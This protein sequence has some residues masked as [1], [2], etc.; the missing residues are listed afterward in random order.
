MLNLSIWEIEVA[1]CIWHD[2]KQKTKA[3]IQHFPLQLWVTWKVESS[4]ESTREVRIHF[5]WLRITQLGFAAHSP[6][7]QQI[8]FAATRIG[9]VSV[10]SGVMCR[11]VRPLGPSSESILAWLGFSNLSFCSIQERNILPKDISSPEDFH[12]RICL[13]QKKAPAPHYWNAIMTQKFFKWLCD[14]L[15]LSQTN[16]S[17]WGGELN[18]SGQ[19]VVLDFVPPPTPAAYQSTKLARPSSQYHNTPAHII[20]IRSG[21]HFVPQSTEICKLA[22]SSLKVCATKNFLPPPHQRCEVSTLFTLKSQSLSK[23][24]WFN[25]Y[26]CVHQ[27]KGSSNKTL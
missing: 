27:T 4:G 15:L 8:M 18:I 25:I 5:S 24:T 26:M 20:Y 16:I 23:A 17:T 2:M 9:Q 3:Q 1:G 10:G 13:D 11:V 21:S 19:T 12:I 7:L 6:G 14:H 22:K